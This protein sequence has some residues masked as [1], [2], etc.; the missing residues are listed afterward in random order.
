MQN[1][2]KS[3]R[4][5]CIAPVRLLCSVYHDINRP[6][7]T[8][9]VSHPPHRLSSGDP[10][11]CRLPDPADARGTHRRPARR[12]RARSRVLRGQPRL[13]STVL[14]PHAYDA[15]RA[16]ATP[17]AVTGGAALPGAAH[18]SG[19]ESARLQSRPRYQYPLAAVLSG[20]PADCPEQKPTRALRPLAARL[21]AA[22]PCPGDHAPSQPAHPRRRR[23][24]RPAEADRP[25]N[26]L[27]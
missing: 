5:R 2:G 26:R 12:Q 9:T 22:A 20:H 17:C 7:L 3:C 4:N 6:D 21:R 13:S 11:Q 1:G 10:P 23:S 25:C 24:A 19:G 15:K 14:P 27:G 16:G 8:A 18:L